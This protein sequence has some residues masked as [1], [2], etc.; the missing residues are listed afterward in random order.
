MK[1]PAIALAVLV[2]GCAAA[3]DDNLAGCT[4]AHTI[5]EKA[6]TAHQ[7]GVPLPGLLE[8]IATLEPDADDVLRD[9]AK[10]ITIAAYKQPRYSTEEFRQDAITDFANA[11]M[12]QCL[13][14]LE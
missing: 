7:A 14:T 8:R 1:A 5:A 10:G 3:A 4:I 12:V 2:S 9:L 6:A 11:V 13:D